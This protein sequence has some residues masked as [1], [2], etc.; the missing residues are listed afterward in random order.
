MAGQR[1]PEEAVSALEQLVAGYTGQ[2][3]GYREW[4]ALARR[5]QER[6]DQGD[7]DGFLRLHAEKDEVA[8]RVRELEQR[9]RECRERLGQ[10]LGSPDLTLQDLARAQSKWS[11]PAVDEA[12]AELRSLLAD[13]EAVIRELEQVEA[14]TERQLRERL[15]G[16]RRELT[17]TRTT[18]RAVRSYRQPALEPGESRF[19]DRK[20]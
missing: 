1:A 14:S 13:L 10:A 5:A 17:E 19:I 6:L 11:E 18:R 16:L 20:G 2:L 3:E 9:V 7:L 8:A 4:L 12:V 15:R